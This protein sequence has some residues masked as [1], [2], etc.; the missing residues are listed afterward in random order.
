MA[1]QGFTG[2]YW[3]L[4][5]NVRVPAGAGAAFVTRRRLWNIFFGSSRLSQFSI[6]HF[7]FIYLCLSSSPS[8][9]SSSSSSFSIFIFVFIFRFLRLLIWFWPLKLLFCASVFLFCLFVCLFLS[10]SLSLSYSLSLLPFFY[11]SD[12]VLFSSTLQ[13][14]FQHLTRR[15]TVGG[16]GY[17]ISILPIW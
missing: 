12:L 5:R 2:F 8:S 10:F 7:L 11:F 15:T 4:I 3:V 13:L 9:S 16:V 14:Y 17:F 1:S 6:F